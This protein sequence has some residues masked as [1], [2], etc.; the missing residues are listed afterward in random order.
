MPLTEQLIQEKLTTVMDPELNVDVVSLG[1]IYGVSVRE[2][3][4]DTEVRPQVHI[5]Y[6]LT[7]P[8]CPL[9]HVFEDLLRQSLTG[10]DG[11]DEYRDVVIELTFD[12]PWIPDMMSEEAKAELGF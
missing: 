10:I 3:Q 6:T 9:S 5:V 12:P 4:T 11:L 8:G 2:I 1:L 7:T